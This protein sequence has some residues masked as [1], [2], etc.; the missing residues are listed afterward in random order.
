[1]LKDYNKENFRC[2]TFL[3]SFLNLIF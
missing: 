1:M 3:S 2:Q